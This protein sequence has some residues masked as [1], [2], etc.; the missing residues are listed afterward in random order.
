MD[1]FHNCISRIPSFPSLQDVSLK[2]TSRVCNPARKTPFYNYRG[3]E[4]V[5]LRTQVLRRLFTALDKPH[6][7]ISTLSIENLQDYSPHVYDQ[8][9]FQ[10]VRAKL[11]SLHL[12]I[13]MESS[14]HGP[15]RDIDIP[16]KHTFYNRELNEHWLSPMQNQLTHLTLYGDDFWGVYPRWDPRGLHFPKLKSLSLGNWSIAHQWQIEWI[17]S[18]GHTLEELYLDDCPIIHAL[19]FK[20]HQHAKLEW[21]EG[22]VEIRDDRWADGHIYPSLRWSSVLPLFTSR[23][24]KLK[25]FGMGHGPWENHYGEWN[26]AFAQRYELPARLEVGRYGIFDCGTL[27]THWIID[28]KMYH[29][30]EVVWDDEAVAKLEEDAERDC[31]WV[32]DAEENGEEEKLQYPGGRVDDQRALDE[33]IAGLKV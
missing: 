23:L 16:E 10:N 33:L 31:C 29:G 18:H 11:T 5:H 2:F 20:P 24:K 9:A 27:P 7:N 22:E 30:Q 28:D 19:R 3:S 6:L 25:R 4:D 1:P 26:R 12:K 32:Y 13:A 21:A 15:D 17:L 8:Q 14:D